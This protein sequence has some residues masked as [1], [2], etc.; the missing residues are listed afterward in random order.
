MTVLKRSKD[1]YKVLVKK[2]G[3][4]G[5]CP[6]AFVELMVSQ[7]EDNALSLLDHMFDEAVA[8]GSVTDEE[9]EAKEEERRKAIAEQE[10][11]FNFDN[12]MAEVMEEKEK[13]D[14]LSLSNEDKK[15]SA[16]A[17]NA[18]VSVAKFVMEMPYANDSEE[19]EDSEDVP[20]LPSAPPPDDDDDDH[21]EEERIRA[22]QEKARL[23]K[24]VCKNPS[25]VFS[26]Y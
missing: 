25:I 6:V 23:A 1:W 4:S 5:I 11:E 2:T 15:D 12:I 21:E 9:K 26:L 18:T 20:D 13:F 24:K 3:A 19:D 17:N 10:S 8:S 14:R 16:E 22:E 7:V